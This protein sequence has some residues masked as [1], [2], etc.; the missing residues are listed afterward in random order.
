VC[1]VGGT[2]E[3]MTMRRKRGGQIIRNATT[4]LHWP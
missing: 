3:R 4:S 2:R 1:G